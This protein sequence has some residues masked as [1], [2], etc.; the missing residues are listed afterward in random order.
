M[1]RRAATHVVPDV[2][3]HKAS[4]GAV[5]Y[6]RWALSAQAY[7][8][9]YERYFEPYIVASRRLARYDETFEGYGNDKDQLHFEL[10]ARHT[11]YV[12]LPDVFVVHFH[13]APTTWADNAQ[14]PTLSRRWRTFAAFFASLQL[15]AGGD[16]D[17]DE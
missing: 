12:V 2:H 9:G 16:A 13:H 6:R 15:P 7:E 5:N 11:R 3:R 14:Q 8:I 10:H 17:D 4:H 1:R